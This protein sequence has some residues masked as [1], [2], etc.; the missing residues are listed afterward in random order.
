MVASASLAAR[1]EGPA[2][3]EH[4]DKIL[5]ETQ[6]KGGEAS[7]DLEGNMVAPF[8]GRKTTTLFQLHRTR[9]DSRDPKLHLNLFSGLWPP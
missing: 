4:K 7:C 8:H 2:A 3:T 1:R 6:G 5:G 9:S